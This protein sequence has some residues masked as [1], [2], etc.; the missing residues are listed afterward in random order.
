M[1]TL[2]QKLDLNSYINEFKKLLARDKDF[3]LEGD[4]NLHFKHIKELESVEFEPP[5]EIKNLD[6]ELVHLSKEGVLHLE[7][8][9][10]FV[11]ICKYFS[12]LKKL[13]FEKSLREWLDKIVIKPEI[14]ELYEY[15]DEKA[16]IKDELDERLKAINQNISLKNEEIKLEFSRLLNSQNISSYL[17]DRQIHLINGEECL[18]LRGGFSSVLKCKILARS[19]SGG[20]YV[21]PLCIE[22][23]LSQKENL[24]SQKEEIYYEYAKKI[25]SIFHKNLSFLKF[26]NKAFDIFDSYSARVLLAKQKDYEF[27]LCDK[28]KDIVLTDF[29]HPVLKNAKKVS[30]DFKKQVLLITGVNAGGKSM[31]LKGIMSACFLSKY[32]LPI[33]IN[34]SKSKIGSFKNFI[35]II[36]DPQNAK[37]DISTFAGRMLEFSKLSDKQDLLLGVDEIELG[38]DA[39]EA[40]CLYTVLISNLIKEKKKIIITT[41]HKK[42]ALLLAK[43][44]EVEL[45]AALYDEK[46]ARVSYEFLKGTIGKS[47]AFESALRYGIK[48]DLVKEARELYGKDKEDLENIVSKNI[49]LE[50]ELK[51]KIKKI[52]NKE[53]KL[54]KLLQRLKEQEESSKNKLNALVK[55]LEFKY[56]E[57]IQEAKKALNFTE[58]KDK[59]RSI[60]KA[61]ELKSKIKI[62]DN[63]KTQTLNIG[64]FVKYNDIKG[65]IISINKNEALIQS[66]NISLRVPLSFLVKIQ[67]QKQKTQSTVK[68]QKTNTASVSLDLHGLRSEEAIEKLDKFISDALIAGFEEVL[69]YH[70]I[71]TGKLAFAVKEFLKTHK[72]VKEF[73]DAPMNQGGFGAKIVK[74]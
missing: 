71:G 62:K 67:Q 23:L 61:N 17:I 6:K 16:Q 28:S 35:S 51:S 26:I 63:N 33:P 45:V 39:N 30:I 53:V 24:K 74:F 15:F 34:S 60:N 68:F 66:D 18:L 65:E 41:H 58:L 8:S 44:E 5:N 3:F 31:L 64:D 22:N 21:L 20:F 36:E 47:Y 7:Q 42:L 43:N 27:V 46:N 38:T 25:S 48:A 73:N 13:K 49:N 29:A 56:Y 57:A 1:K 2:I 19:N 12:Y 9:F 55:D 50:L 40:S 52:E 4:Y 37:N 54:D 10:E 11:R 59:Q 69:V 14:L 70:G 32:L 72:S